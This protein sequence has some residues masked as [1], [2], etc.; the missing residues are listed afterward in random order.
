METILGMIAGL[1]AA[2]WGIN[3]VSKKRFDSGWPFKSH[4]LRSREL[5]LNMDYNKV[6][7][8]S[9]SAILRFKLKLEKFDAD[10][11]ELRALTGFD[12]RTFGEI[13]IIS[14]KKVGE[15]VAVTIESMPAFPFVMLD[16]GRNQSNVDAL[17]EL[18][19]N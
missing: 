10:K 19:K 7:E 2:I 16:Y 6:L 13:I 14:H 11:G 4:L 9:K 15:G 5:V 12:L 3:F 18:I 17:Y 1:A 8:K